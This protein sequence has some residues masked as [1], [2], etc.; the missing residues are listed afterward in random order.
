MLGSLLGA[1]KKKPNQAQTASSPLGDLV[2]GLTGGQQAGALGDMVG[3]LLGG[4][5]QGGLGGMLGGGDLTANPMV[6]GVVQNLAEQLG[7]PPQIAQT[8]V[9]FAMSK[10]LPALTAQLQ[11]QG[12]DQAVSTGGLDLNDLLQRVG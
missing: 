9:A 2:G 10:L 12:A 5:S 7:L 1:K 6:A 11:G 3:G 4:G 8:V